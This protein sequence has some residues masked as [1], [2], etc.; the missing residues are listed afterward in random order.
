[1]QDQDGQNNN[2]FSEADL[3]KLTTRILQEDKL[4][5]KQQTGL[6]DDI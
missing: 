1:M 6:A 5:E 4:K 3:L 2:I